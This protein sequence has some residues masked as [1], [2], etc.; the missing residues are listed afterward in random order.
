MGVLV[1]WKPSRD[2]VRCLI[3]G[4]GAVVLVNDGGGEEVVEVEAAVIK[5]LAVT[6]ILYPK[7]MLILRWKTKTKTKEGVEAN[8]PHR[9]P[10]PENRLRSEPI[11]PENR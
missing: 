10:T 6:L 7:L 11:A 5:P 4:R 3:D 2:R 8:L 9:K 1:F